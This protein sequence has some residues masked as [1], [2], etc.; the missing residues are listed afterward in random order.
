MPDETPVPSQYEMPDPT[1][2][3][4]LLLAQIGELI[5]RERALGEHLRVALVERDN[6]IAALEAL[7]KS[8]APAKP[9]RTRPK[10]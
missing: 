3:R 1:L 4:N 9:P 10:R 7:S 6:A 8:A 2:D 5:V